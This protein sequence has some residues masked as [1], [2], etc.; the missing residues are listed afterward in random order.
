MIESRKN[1]LAWAYL[2]ATTVDQLPT[3]E[4]D[5]LILQRWAT[6][7]SSFVNVQSVD[8]DH[9]EDRFIIQNQRAG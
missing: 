2:I 5:H 6:R 1:W 7:W 3:G 9:D 4:G 8:K